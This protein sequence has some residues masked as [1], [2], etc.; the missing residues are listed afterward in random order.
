MSNKIER[1]SSCTVCANPTV[2]AVVDFGSQPPANRFIAIDS[3]KKIQEAYPL[4]LGY[5]S[6]CE[7]IQLARRMPMQ[8]VK[9]RFAWL[10][11]NEPEQHLDDVANQLR[12]LPG[13][14][15]SSRM[16][17]V[18]YKD[19]STLDR[20]TKLGLPSS[21]CLSSE[22]FS[23]FRMPALAADLKTKYAPV[24]LLLA[25]HIVE[26]AVDAVGLITELKA[27]IAPGGY[28]VLELPDSEKILRAGNHA[29][30]WEEHISYFTEQ[31]LP[32]LAEK[33][34]AKLAW[35]ARYPYPY[36]DSLMAA[37][38]FT[39]HLSV[40]PKTERALDVSGLLQQFNQGFAKARQEWRELLR[41]YR[42]QGHQLAV[43]GAG[44]LAAKWINFLCLSDLVD[45]VI[46]DHPHKAGM[47]MPGSKLPILPSSALQDQGIKV[48]ISTLSPESEQKVRLKL[49][50]YFDEGGIF[51]PAFKTARQSS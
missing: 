17:G 23:I 42:D 24:D 25:R 20:L 50:K 45:C 13:I 26:H 32:I 27:L 12:Q 35:T 22:D 44:H 39:S 15:A 10:T 6:C 9:P 7:T 33:V 41:N 43:F 11:Y 18:T 30:I 47:Y 4:G 46:D 49:S 21:T 38:Q 36:E 34:N 51:I 48:C 8:A 19:Q 1:S 40:P 14:S 31:S 16:L 3:I 28:L 37:F 29:F 2:D 5:C